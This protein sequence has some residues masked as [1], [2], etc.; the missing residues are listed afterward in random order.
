MENKIKH[1][2]GDKAPIVMQGIE[3]LLAKYKDGKPQNSWVT[4]DEVM[5][6]TYGDSVRSPGEMPLQTL[7]EFLTN[8]VNSGVTAVHILPCFPYTSDDGFSVVDYRVIDPDLGDWGDVEKLGSHFDLMLDAVINHASASSPWFQGFLQDDE[9]YQDYFVVADPVLDYSS[10]TRPRALPLLTEVETPSG[11]KHVWTTFSADQIDLNF[12]SPQVLLE[13]LDILAMYAHKGSRFIRLDAIGFMYKKLGTTCMHLE[14]THML[15]QVMR[16]F[17]DI[18]VP[19]TILITETNVPHKDNISYLGDGNEAH[20]VYQF[21]LPPLTL[22]SF[23]KQNARKLMDWANSLEPTPR[24]TTFFNFLASH[25]GIGMRPTEGILTLEERD[26]MVENVIARGGFV[27]FR[28]NGD[29]TKSPYELNINYMDALT[30]PEA[31]DAER[32]KRSLAAHAILLSLAGVPAVY[33]HSLLGSR[34]DRQAA[35]DSGINRRI[36]RAKLDK[37]TVCEELQADSLRR[38]VFEQMSE[39]IR[40]RR[41]Q[42][43]FAPQAAQ[44]VVY[45]DDRIFSIR[46]TNEE[47]GQQILVLVNVSSEE[48]SVDTGIQGMDLITGQTVDGVLVVKPCCYHWVGA[49]SK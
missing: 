36:N 3:R 11:K 25:D 46:R 12:E 37:Q 28:D 31:S 6:I 22:F 21:P 48:V 15:V 1:I 35:L 34:N 41:A 44:Q 26:M 29:G 2:Y 23:Y 30:D 19:G 16:E 8:D 13:I 4:E 5:L 45:L 49:A 40:T 43:A 9:R 42:S 17:L 33:I 14:E 32:A 7:D 20:M 47:T 18:A 27:N 39:L 38:S 10:V 24:H